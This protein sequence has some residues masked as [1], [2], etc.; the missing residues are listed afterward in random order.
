MDRLVDRRLGAR[1]IDVDA[2]GTM[3]ARAGVVVVGGGIVGAS[4]AFHLAEAGA[5]DVLVLERNILGSGTTWHAAGLVAGARG[6]VTLTGLA[7]YGRE[8]YAHLQD[9]TGVDVGMRRPGSLSIARTEG[10]VDELRYACDVARQCGVAA[11]MVDVEEIAALWPL[12]RTDGMR[13]GLF[14]PDDGH[15]NPGFAGLALA[16]LAHDRGVAI[17]EG[18]DVRRVLV[19]PDGSG[20]GRAV[21]VET[22]RGTVLADT[23]VLACGLWSRE[24]AATAGVSLPLYPAEH[25]HVR[26]AADLGADL[27][28]PVLRDLDSSCY[29]RQEGGRLLVGAFEPDGLPRAVE[30]IDPGGFAE[31]PADWEHFAPIRAR[32]EAT[33]PGLAEVGYDRFLNAP[34]SFTPDTAF[35]L[36]ETAEVERLYV[37]AGMNSQG[38]IYAPGIGRELATWIVTG[39]PGFDASG[40]DVRRFSPQQGNRRYLH[41]RT[42]ESLGRLYAMHWPHHQ[43][44][45]ARDV[46]RGPLH[47][48]VARLGARFGEIDGAERADWYADAPLDPDADPS[49]DWGY[50][51][52]R[53]GW[54]DSVAAEHRA[55]REAVALFDLSWFATIEVAGPDALAVCQRAATAEVD[56]PV[57]GVV[58]TLFL[59]DAGGIELDGTITRVAPE[60]F[61][62]V[63]PSTTRHRSLWHLRRLA[64]GRA[65]AVV[66]V[67]AGLATIAVMGPR[68]RDLLTR[69]SPE[70]WSDAAQPYY[71]GRTVEI[72]DGFAYAL[73]L[74]YVGEL[75]Y[76]LYVEADLARDVFRAVW[77]AGREL[78]IRPAGYFALDTLR[79]EK[80]YR[81][82]GHDMGPTDDPYSVGLGFAVAK[83]KAGYVG[84]EAVAALDPRSPARRM[85]HVALDDPGPLLVHDEAVHCDGRYVGRM[86]SGGYGHTLGRSVGLAS[87]AP[88]AD[89]SGEIT[90]ECAGVLVPATVSR[91]PFY[92]PQGARLRG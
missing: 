5:T 4:I 48:E 30:G 60:R 88:D 71:A 22:S 31:F 56:V 90:V 77:D 13:A 8:L 67:S 75:G 46:R 62:V 50:S 61:W 47:D 17:R 68:S 87:L 41:A 23:V 86:T 20:G 92:D 12:A 15:V 32:V 27:D 54:F 44:T 10:R 55:A 42:R 52:R 57:G 59:N 16:R 33:I 35:L 21:G 37:A 53:P 51:Y 26:S 80:G 9:R 7:H 25:V 63:T 91:R 85:V 28:L 70:D 84:A 81:H 76:E 82:L 64:R 39:T 6:T 3:P 34:E 1:A 38:I 18:V 40:V 58:Y 43:W 29:V 65:A 69:V 14:F 2:T 78:G 89:L 83:G 24:L 79:L 36:G 72:A 11:R 66:D 74:S 73:R 49:A 45:T 19:D